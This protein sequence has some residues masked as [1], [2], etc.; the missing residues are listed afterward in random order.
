LDVFLEDAAHRL[1]D[2]PG[3]WG[4]CYDLAQIY[5]AGHLLAMASYGSVGGSSSIASA[6]AGGLQVSFGSTGS[7]RA[8]SAPTRWQALLSELTLACG[9]SGPMVIVGQD[10]PTCY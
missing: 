9:L 1:G 4:D 5:L 2:D 10:L 6:S 3:R 8:S 7:S